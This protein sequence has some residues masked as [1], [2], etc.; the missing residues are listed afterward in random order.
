[1]VP[2]LLP[3]LCW[4]VLRWLR[5]QRICIVYFLLLSELFL[6]ISIVSDC[7]AFSPAYC[8][9]TPAHAKSPFL[10]P[11]VY[12]FPF[13]YATG[14]YSFSILPDGTTDFIQLIEEM[15][16]CDFVW[17]HLWDSLHE[18]SSLLFEFSSVFICIRY[19]LIRF[20]SLYTTAVMLMSKS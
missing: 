19:P 17:M 9:N 15:G 11:S 14:L 2:V 12:E 8:L 18:Y 3:F 6:N 1:M 13:R 16:S 5:P 7:P 4:V 20:D 10:D